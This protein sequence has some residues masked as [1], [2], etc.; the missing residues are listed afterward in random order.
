MIASCSRTS[1]ISPLTYALIVFLV[2]LA[3]VTGAWM[4]LNNSDN[5]EDGAAANSTEADKP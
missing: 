3:V 2:V 1:R 4:L 5:A